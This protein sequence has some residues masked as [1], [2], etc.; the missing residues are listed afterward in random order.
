MARLAPLLPTN[1]CVATQFRVA[2][3]ATGRIRRTV[4]A[5]CGRSCFTSSDS[6][7]TRNPA[8]IPSRTRG[9]TFENSAGDRTMKSIRQRFQEEEPV[10]IVISRGT[11]REHTPRLTAYMWALETEETLEGAEAKAA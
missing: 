6:R 10:G 3:A 4:L 8:S 5:G 2:I 1:G 7:G 9:G 11:E